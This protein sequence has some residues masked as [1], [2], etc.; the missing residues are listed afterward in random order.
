[1]YGDTF[2]MKENEIILENELILLLQYLSSYL[3]LLPNLL[4][5]FL[6]YNFQS[7]IQTQKTS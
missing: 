4:N 6:V 7:W 1:M 2:K 5:G 3:P